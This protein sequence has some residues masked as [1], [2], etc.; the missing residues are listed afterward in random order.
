MRI[1]KYTDAESSTMGVGN[2]NNVRG[3]AVNGKTQL[4]EDQRDACGEQLHPPMHSF[5]SQ[6]SESLPSPQ[7]AARRWPAGSIAVFD[8]KL[9]AKQGEN[10]M[11]VA[12]IAPPGNTKSGMSVAAMS[13]SSSGNMLAVA[14]EDGREIYVYALLHSVL[15]TSHLGIKSDPLSAHDKSRNQLGAA[16]N[17]H[18]IRS[19]LMYRLQRGVTQGIISSFPSISSE[20]LLSHYPQG[21]HHICLQ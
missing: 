2:S 19:Q 18:K 16:G 12:S 8:M 21:A 9:G 7:D 6:V 13:F 10:H 11:P 4:N 1:Q 17:N 14:H 5:V 20:N 3:G 15:S